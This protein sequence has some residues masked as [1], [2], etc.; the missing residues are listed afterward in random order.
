[1]IHLK[2]KPYINCI[3]LKF[4]VFSLAYA[5]SNQIS[6]EYFNLIQQKIN[7]YIT[8][9]LE[10]KEKGWEGIVK[11]KFILNPNG[12]IKQIQIAQ[13]SGHPLLD[14]AAISAIKNASPYPFPKTYS[15]ELEI[16]LPIKYQN[17]FQYKEKQELISASKD[18]KMKTLLLSLQKSKIET[19]GTKFLLPPQDIQSLLEVPSFPSGPFLPPSQSNFPTKNLAS[20]YAQEMLL[21]KETI[22]KQPSILSQELEYYVDLA[23]KNSQ[24]TQVAREE[25]ELAQIKVIEA[26]RNLFPAFKISSYTTEGDVYRI[27]YEERETKFEI[28]QPLFY[29][30]RLGD[31]FNQAKINLEITKRNYDRQ[32][33]DVR[34]KTET[35]YYNLIAS[36]MHL[37]LKE[38]LKQEAKELV[39]KIEKLS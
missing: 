24:P 35:A 6:P 32:K 10:A 36:R 19:P 9:P 23:I 13:S 21:P 12:Q 38:P 28:N 25:I 4:L 17:P 33:F 15:K 1:M 26:Q 3:I 30:G 22:E 20:F 27:K 5:Q 29:G 37:A 2:I 34:Y 16:L 14:E 7:S 18:T 39:E 11:V 31:T 8:Y